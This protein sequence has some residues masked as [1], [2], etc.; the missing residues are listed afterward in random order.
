M[1]DNEKKSKKINSPFLY[2]LFIMIF[3][4]AVLLIILSILNPYFSPHQ[5]F[6][7]KLVRINLIYTLIPFLIFAILYF[8]LRNRQKK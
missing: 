6:H 4:I 3:V 8:I 7:Y 1:P 5:R 2:F